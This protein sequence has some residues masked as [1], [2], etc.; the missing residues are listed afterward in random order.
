MAS[1]RLD[2]VAVRAELNRIG[3]RDAERVARD[4]AAAAQRYAPRVSGRLASSITVSKA[5]SLKGP[6]WRVD[7]NVPYAPFVEEDTRPHVIRPRKPGGVLRFK[8]GGQTVF[9][10]IVHHPGTKGQHFLGRA[11]RDVGISNGYNVRVQ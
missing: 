9:A 5:F 8:V 4:I 2:P 6:L 10:R 7:A 11:T 1:I 3:N